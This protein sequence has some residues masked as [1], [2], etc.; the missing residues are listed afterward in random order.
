MAIESDLV[1]MD[2]VSAVEYPDL[3]RQFRI[4][5]VPKTIINDTTDILG[6]VPEPQFVEAVVGTDSAD[7]T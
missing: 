1:T 7:N 4:T 6:A 2:A 3:V 5:G